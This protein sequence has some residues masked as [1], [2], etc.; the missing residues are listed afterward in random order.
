MVRT[1]VPLAVALAAAVV[2]PGPNVV[3]VAVQSVRDRR[4]G[5]WTAA[6][7]A[8]G[9]MLWAGAAMAGMGALLLQ[10]RPLFLAFKWAGAAYLVFLAVRLW[11][12]AASAGDGEPDPGH[13]PGPGHAPEPGAG[14]A[15]QRRPFLRGLVVDLANPKAALFFTSLYASLLP[16]HL[17][18]GAAAAVLAAT[19][20]IVYG[21]YFALA[22]A[23]SRPPAQRAYRRATRAASRIAAGIM[24]ALGVRLALT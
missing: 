14:V 3:A 7:V 5:C 4:T 17:D 16:A 11:S 19:A 12:D 20:A 23:L 13:A 9:D 21:W 10:S 2:V 1:L 22:V 24:G 15:T 18:V 8:T 6:G